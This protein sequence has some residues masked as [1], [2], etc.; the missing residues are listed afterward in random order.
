MVHFCINSVYSAVLKLTRA[1]HDVDIKFQA[2]DLFSICCSMS[3]YSKS[4]FTSAIKT[5]TAQ[6]FNVCIRRKNSKETA[7]YSSLAL[8]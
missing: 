2:K 3:Y 8:G 6:S 5:N 7:T 4:A 1:T